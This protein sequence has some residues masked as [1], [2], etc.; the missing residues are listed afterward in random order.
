VS[1]MTG[2]P[3]RHVLRE[4]NQ[5]LWLLAAAPLFWAAHF[6][7]SYITAAIWCAK[8]AGPD[9]SLS[10]VRIA[11]GVYTAIALLG[12]GVTARIAWRKHRYAGASEPLDADSP[13]GRHRFMGHATLLLAALSAVAT[14]YA[15]LAAV[16]IRSCQ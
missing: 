16:F 7:L 2:L 13:A 14:L 10:G 12:I 11:I 4:E 9:G 1:A 5:S 15:A 3:Q 8:Y 6:L